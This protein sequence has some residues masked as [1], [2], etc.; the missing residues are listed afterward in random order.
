MEV[1]LN[2]IVVLESGEVLWIEP[3]LFDPTI[4]I[5]ATRIRN[6]IEYEILDSVQ[7]DKLITTTVKKLWDIRSNNY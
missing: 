7:E 4:K 6:Y 2:E 1:I 3:H 5:G